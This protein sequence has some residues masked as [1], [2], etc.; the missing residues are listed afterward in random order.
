MFWLTGREP[1]A[2]P[3]LVTAGAEGVVDEPPQDGSN[4]R[5][6]RT[7]TAARVLTGVRV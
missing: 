7:A 3:A 2:A 4:S 5:T 1:V 6:G